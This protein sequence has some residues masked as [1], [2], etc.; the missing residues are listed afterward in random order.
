LVVTGANGGGKFTFL[1]SVGLAQLMMQCGMFVPA[2]VFRA[3]IRTGVFSHFRREEDAVIDSG[4]LDQELRR[5]SGVV[6]VLQ[7]RGLLLCN[8]P[9]AS[10]NDPEGSEIA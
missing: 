7:P 1:R 9:F 10:T 8:E 3:G 4:K 2:N 5:M 6:D